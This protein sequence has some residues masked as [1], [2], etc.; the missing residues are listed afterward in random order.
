MSALT[1]RDQIAEL[2]LTHDVS[3]T[4]QRLDVGEVI[5]AKPQ[6]LSA[7]Q[8]I[9][10]IRQLGSRVSKA[11]VYNTLN[12]FCERGLLRTVNVDPLRQ[13]YD[14]TIE[15]HFHFYNVDTGELTDIPPTAVQLALD[16]ALP[17]GTE[18]AGVDV[19]VRVRSRRD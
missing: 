19:V 6:H 16:T 8:V 10:R 9:A 3:P 17:D 18:Q 4:P 5:L 1:T 11:T 2:L 15:P 13:Y 12:L 7:D 14:P